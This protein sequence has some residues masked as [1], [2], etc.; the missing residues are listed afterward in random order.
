[1]VPENDAVRV[2]GRRSSAQLKNSVK[3]C[4]SLLSC[5]EHFEPLNSPRRQV[6]SLNGGVGPVN[7]GENFDVR[8]HI[9][10]DDLL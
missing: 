3:R 5:S 1:M 8:T 6:Q 7:L 9:A 10:G 2:A 4:G